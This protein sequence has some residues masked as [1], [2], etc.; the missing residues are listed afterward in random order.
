MSEALFLLVA[1]GRHE[2]RSAGT[3]P[4]AVAHDNVVTAMREL[5]IDLSDRTPQLLTNELGQWAD[6]VIT[7]GCGDECPVIPGKRYLD[8]ALRD[9]KNLSIEEVRDIRDDI[10]DRVDALVKVLDRNSKL[11]SDVRDGGPHR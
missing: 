7:M 4:A 3:R 1:A 9:P 5:H 2:A 11:K 6:V 8:W 10:S